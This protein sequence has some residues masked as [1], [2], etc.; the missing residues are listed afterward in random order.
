VPVKAHVPRPPK[1]P[2][3]L[4]GGAR[5]FWTRLQTE[6]GIA[7]QGGLAALELAVR[8]FARMEEARRLL[9]AEGVVVK[10]R[11]GQSKPHPAAQ[12]ERDARAGVLAALRE[13]H[14]DVEPI[15]DR[16][17]RPPGR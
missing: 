10:D 7:D 14:L 6:Y 12:I 16:I 11:W 8:A 1:P 15:R 13:L 2:K 3:D 4:K 9:D 5:D 17:G